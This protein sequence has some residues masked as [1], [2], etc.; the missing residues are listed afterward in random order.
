[1]SV[2]GNDKFIIV[3]DTEVGKSS[4]LLRF[5]SNKFTERHELTI[6]MEFGSVRKP[7]TLLG[8]TGE[9]VDAEA[10]IQIWDTAGT[11]SFL[12]V[13]RSYYIGAHAGFL[14]QMSNLPDKK[15]TTRQDKT[16]Q[17]PTSFKNSHISPC[18]RLGKLIANLQTHCKTL[19]NPKL[20][21]F[22]MY[23]NGP[24]STI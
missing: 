11:E 9:D 1:M 13:T 12:A 18:L 8:E 14:H 21:S 15:T 16:R 5:I 17:V 23:V 2:D 10:K 6:G 19:K 3:G 24:H 20:W 4:L 22:S 7:L